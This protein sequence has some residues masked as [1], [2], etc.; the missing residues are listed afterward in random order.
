MTAPAC[1]LTALAGAWPAPAS[2]PPEA[3]L[4][5]QDLGSRA[6]LATRAFHNVGHADHGL[7]LLVHAADAHQ[8]RWSTDPDAPAWRGLDETEARL[9]LRRAILLGPG[10]ISSREPRK[11]A[12][13]P[14]TAPW[15]GAP[16]WGLMVVV[17][18]RSADWPLGS[19]LLLPTTLRTH[20]V[21]PG[22]ETI[23]A[24][25]ARLNTLFSRWSGG[26]G[27]GLD[28]DTWFDHGP[29]VRGREAIEQAWR[30]QYTQTRA[31][32]SDGGGG[33]AASSLARCVPILVSPWTRIRT[34]ASRQRPSLPGR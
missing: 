19:Q 17:E 4:T 1:A 22:S 11:A 31:A 25:Q 29:V 18:S 15:V 13:P 2:P 23:A 3:G 32:P 14:G 8:L 7:R 16:A 12:D 5:R 6:R 28:A 27:T 26:P 34:P 20:L 9:V 24:C 30:R 21:V 10:A 33:T